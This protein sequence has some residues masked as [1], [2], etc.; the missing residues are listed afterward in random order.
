MRPTPPPPADLVAAWRR[1]AECFP[2]R[3]IGL[4]DRRGRA[5]EWRRYPELERGFALHA[6]RLARRGV[7]P[8]DRVL[9]SLGTSWEWL[10]AWFGAL[11][12]GALPVA[13]APPEGLGSPRGVLDRAEGVARRLGASLLVCSD[14]L[15]QAIR[16]GEYPT[17]SAIAA[18]PAAICALEPANGGSMAGARAAGIDPASTAFLQL[19]SG[20]TGVPRA[21]RISHRAAT[22]NPVASAEAIGRPWGAPAWEWQE[23]HVLW[24]PLYH[25]MGLVGGILYALLNGLDL[26]LASPRAFLSRPRAWLD[27][28]SAAGASVSPAPNFAYQLCVE[29]VGES[30]R[31]ELDLSRWRAA[32]MGAE[33]VR[34]E[35]ARAFCAAFARSG[36]DA[37]AARP[38][39]GL[40]EATLAV[41]FDCAGEGVRTATVPDDGRGTGELS[42]VVSVGVPVVDTEVR[43]VAADGAPLPDGH[44]GEVRVRGPGVFDGY[45]DDD[46]ATRDA[47]DGGWLRTGDLGFLRAGELYLT[48]RTKEILIVRGQNLMPH[49]IEWIV[50][51]VVGAGGACRVGAF[52]VPR[53]SGEEPVVVVELS[54]DG[55]DDLLATE[56]EIRSRVGRRLSLALADV[57]FVRRGKIPKT[58]SGKVQRRELRARYLARDLERLS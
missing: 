1:A 3:G 55:P 33:M 13:L 47:L 30:E 2:E 42:E 15:E 56:R 49:E 27:L 29:R 44:V 52:S 21:A 4:V 51:E 31:A 34:A 17:L 58:T 43:V 57:A 35:T 11:F 10:D 20:S 40:A 6:R 39:Y 54:G 53:G 36:L 14:T 46:E 5:T 45:W 28:V 50:E 8:G 26:H 18:T 37:A 16:E 48:G 32:L 38:C 22:H 7:R 9:V 25:D 19:T 12:L 41:T 24:L 23:R